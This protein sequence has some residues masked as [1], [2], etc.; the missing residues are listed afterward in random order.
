MDKKKLEV[1]VNKKNI[2]R[3]RKGRGRLSK[4]DWR[5]K[6]RVIEKVKEHK[7]LG[8]ALKRNGNQEVHVKDRMKKA[9][10]LMGQVWGIGKRKFEAD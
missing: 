4:R 8:Y 7:Y 9:A 5:W 1:N 3:F 2:M 10:M 6:G